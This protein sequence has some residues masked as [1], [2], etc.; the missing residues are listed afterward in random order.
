MNFRFE[1]D[2][3][4]VRNCGHVVH[5]LDLCV[6][7]KGN[8]GGE[9]PVDL[10]FQ[11]NEVGYIK[12]TYIPSETWR[13]RYTGDWGMV[14]WL[15]DFKGTCGLTDFKTVEDEDG[16][17]IGTEEFLHKDLRKTVNVLS[18][19][20]DHHRDWLCN[21]GE[22]EEMSEEALEAAFDHY[23]DE[24]W[25]RYE[26]DYKRSR[27]FHVDKPRVDFIRVAKDHRRNGYGTA[28]YRRMTEELDRRLGLSLHDGGL[29]SDEAEAAWEKLV[30]LDWN[31]ATV[32]KYPKKVGEGTKTRYKLSFAQDKQAA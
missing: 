11:G 25:D 27:R 31:E 10:G 29:Q 23:T 5:R 4:D 14:R 19:E 32:E 8:S 1:K 16:E 3:E 22:L 7:E 13:E 9:V 20:I 21:T 18:K 28:L 12:V 30:M 6:D 2:V 17:V 24:L 15:A 26:E